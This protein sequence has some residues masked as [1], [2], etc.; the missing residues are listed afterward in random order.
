MPVE[1]EIEGLVREN[2]DG[3]EVIVKGGK[4]CFLVLNEEV[5]EVWEGVLEFDELEF[6]VERAKVTVLPAISKALLPSRSRIASAA[7]R[8]K[9]K[10]PEPLL[11]TFNGLNPWSIRVLFS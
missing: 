3:D 8:G 9:T 5:E 2:E 11:R 6:M 7:G 4:A 1:E 10:L